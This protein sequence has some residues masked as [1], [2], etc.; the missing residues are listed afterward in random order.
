MISILKMRRARLGEVESLGHGRRANTQHA[1]SPAHGGVSSL[2][3]PRAHG[4]GLKVTIHGRVSAF[5]GPPCAFLLSGHPPPPPA[6]APKIGTSR[7]CRGFEL[8]QIHPTSPLKSMDTFSW[9][10]LLDRWR[11]YR[12]CGPDLGVTLKPLL[13]CSPMLPR[14]EGHTAVLSTAACAPVPC[15]ARGLGHS[16]RP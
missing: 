1:Q 4:P 7:V 8:S 14:P 16:L 5:P 13:I 15:S 9:A 10:G 6:A 12:S 11:S 3:A 2:A